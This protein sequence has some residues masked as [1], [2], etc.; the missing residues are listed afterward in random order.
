MIERTA[1]AQ[2]GTLNVL[3]ELNDPELYRRVVQDG[4]AFAIMPRNAFPDLETSGVMAREIVEP[5]IERVQSIV[6]AVEHPL[7]PAGEAVRSTL[8]ELIATM[9]ADGTL[10]ARLLP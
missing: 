8:L 7:T 10:E 6:W 1:N 3:Y 4:L 5:T 9:V 2:G